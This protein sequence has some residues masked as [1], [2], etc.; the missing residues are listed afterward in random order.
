MR[1]YY[2]IASM[3]DVGACSLTDIR[4]IACNMLDSCNPSVGITK[5]GRP[6]AE[7]CCRM[8]KKLNGKMWV[9]RMCYFFKIC[10]GKGYVLLSN[11]KVQRPLS[12]RE[13]KMYF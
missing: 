3:D 1:N 5:N 10:E 12:D 9:E 4:I 2:R 6:F 13:I 7:V 8:A 11:G